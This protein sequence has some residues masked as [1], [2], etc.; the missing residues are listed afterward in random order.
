MWVV[1]PFFS[2]GELTDLQLREEANDL[3]ELEQ[4][5]AEP[6]SEDQVKPFIWQI[7]RSLNYLKNSNIVHRDLKIENVMLEN[8]LSDLSCTQKPFIRLIDFGFDTF[9]V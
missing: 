8:E 9:Q 6:L 5:E 1:S 4:Q 7:L 2:G 3:A